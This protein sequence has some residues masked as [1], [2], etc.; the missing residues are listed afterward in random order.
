MKEIEGVLQRLG[1]TPAEAKVYLALLQS[2]PVKVGRIIEKSGLQSSTAHNTLHALLQNGYCTYVLRGKIK[3][4][5]AVHPS[6]ILTSYKEKEQEFARLIPRLEILQSLAH[7]KQEAEI[8][9]GFK[10][11]TT[12]LNMLIEDA[13]P[14][15]DYSF[16]ATDQQEYNAEIQAFFERYDR[17]RKEK[18]LKVRGLARQELKPLF[19]KRET[20]SMRYVGHPIPTNIS[21]CHDRMALI[22]WSEKPTGILIQSKPLIESQLRFFKVLWENAHL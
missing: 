9:E 3:I 15:D 2:G 12:M 11:V 19:E 16:F 10:G 5:Q 14:G 4:Y 8:Y 1:F 18:L 22:S 17:K 13:Q 6:L 7:E 21:I 20:L